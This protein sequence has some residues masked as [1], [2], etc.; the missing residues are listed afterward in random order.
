MAAEHPAAGFRHADME[1]RPVER[2]AARQGE[3]FK[4]AI[5]GGDLCAASQSQPHHRQAADAAQHP[6]GLRRLSAQHLLQGLAQILAGRQ[7]QGKDP[8]GRRGC[9]GQ[10][11]QSERNGPRECILGW[12]LVYLDQRLRCEA[13]SDDGQALWL[14]HN[15]KWKAAEPWRCWFNGPAPQRRPLG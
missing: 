6:A 9:G 8:H 12:C 13:V 7:P 15:G 4:V 2:Q 3:D 10:T 14:L 11:R 5:E 1:V